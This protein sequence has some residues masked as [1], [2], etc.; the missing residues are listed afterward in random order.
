MKIFTAKQIYAA[1][2]FTLAEQNMSSYELMERASIQLFNWLHHRL[3]GAQVKIKLFCGIGN[4]GG[5]G[6]ALARHLQEH[7]YNIEVIVVNYSKKRSPDFLANLER[8][9]DRKIWPNFLNPDTGLPSID[10]KD[11]VIDALFGIGLNRSPEKWVGQIIEHL[12]NSGA[13]VVSVDV[14]SG[15][16]LDRAVENLKSVVKANYV[17]SFQFPKLVFHSKGIYHRFA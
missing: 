2:Q 15:L 17:L 6:L 8:L 5:D 12:N 7:G 10:F 4:N 9:K 3:Q 14:P 16:F 1:D 13:F 11:I